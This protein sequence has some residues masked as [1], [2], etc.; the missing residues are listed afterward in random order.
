MTDRHSPLD[1]LALWALWITVYG[2][3]SAVYMSFQEDVS[4]S[5]FTTYREVV[6][7]ALLVQTCSRLAR[8]RGLSTWK[9]LAL[10]AVGVVQNP[11]YV[12]HLGTAEAWR[13]VDILTLV[14]S[15]VALSERRSTPSH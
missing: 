10:G 12:I 3:I 9:T 4:Y 2:P 11:I 5:C 1:R 6:F 13:V 14:L 8:P 7:S 15:S